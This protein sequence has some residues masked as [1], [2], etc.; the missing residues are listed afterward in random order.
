MGI[1]WRIWWTEC[2]LRIRKNG[3][4]VDFEWESRWRYAVFT[5]NVVFL[6]RDIYKF[7]Y[8]TT[9]FTVSCMQPVDIVSEFQKE[10]NT[11]RGMRI[12]DNILSASKT[13][14]GICLC[15]RCCSRRRCICRMRSPGMMSIPQHYIL[16][17]EEA[18]IVP[19]ENISL[20]L[21]PTFRSVAC[22]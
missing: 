3:L 2:S 21:L 12:Q 9:Q 1:S 15:T 7:V 5:S 22:V 11:S 20:W 14:L 8:T 19:L 10:N 16:D 6:G 13:R 18:R 17:I 4:N